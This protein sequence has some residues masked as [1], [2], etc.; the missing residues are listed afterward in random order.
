MNRSSAQK[1]GGSLAVVAVLVAAFATA[2]SSR[3]AR[4][5]GE[6]VI[7]AIVPLT[8]P[9]A[10]LGRVEKSAMEIGEKLV[11]A[12][13]EAVRVVY[14]DDQS[15]PEVAVQILA[16]L[17]ADRVPIVIGPSGRGTCLALAPLV[18][19]GPVDYCLSPTMHAEPG[20][21]VFMTGVDTY[22]LDRAMIRFARMRGW[23]KLGLITSTD[24]T[25]NDAVKAFDMIVKERE[26]RGMALV[27][28]VTFAP[29]DI[30]V[31]AQL[32][33]IKAAQPDAVLA[34]STGIGIGTVLKGMNQL[35]ITVP[36]ATSFGNMTFSQMK[37]W[38]DFL[39]K[40]L[41]FPTT[42]WPGRPGLDPRIEAALKELNLAYG[43]AG[44]KPDAGAD[45]AWDPLMI[46]VRVLKK[47]GPDATVDQVRDALQHMRGF[48]GINGLYDFERY[49]QRGLGDQNAVV[50]KW[51]ADRGA[52]E[53]VS[54]FGGSPL[55]ARR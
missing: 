30:S 8:G 3:A 10:F 49:P 12:R 55:D 9:E 46:V 25:G 23:R 17:T 31:T 41:Y 37:N 7:H 27:E 19:K 50:T 1:L 35:G 53:V 33:R 44:E 54:K 16:Q 6:L 2:F 4:A 14:H 43:A 20:S 38:A 51:I 22:D 13:G 15:K 52:W 28:R 47:V 40:E 18:T 42:P 26:N 29:T 5:A 11:N 36:V 45:V 21:Y 32:A 24:A 48:A 39:P 34:W